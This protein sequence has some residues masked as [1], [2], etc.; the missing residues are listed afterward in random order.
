MEAKAYNLLGKQVLTFTYAYS[1]N[2]QYS[3]GGGALIRVDEV[4]SLVCS[5]NE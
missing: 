4:R 5:G 2:W 3:I 1:I